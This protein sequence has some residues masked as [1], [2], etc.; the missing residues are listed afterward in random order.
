MSVCCSLCHRSTPTTRVCTHEEQGKHPSYL[1][2]SGFGPSCP[3]GH[4]I[5]HSFTSSCVL[6]CPSV[7]A[8]Q[9]LQ[10]TLTSPAGKAELSSNQSIIYLPLG[11]GDLQTRN[12]PWCVLPALPSTPW[13]VSPEYPLNP[14]A[15]IGHP[16]SLTSLLPQAS[17]VLRMH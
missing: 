1:T 14:C 13:K 9:D 11:T 17:L 16:G 6:P 8:P 4:L 7:K 12:E 3:W 10:C 5:S 15:H 2:S